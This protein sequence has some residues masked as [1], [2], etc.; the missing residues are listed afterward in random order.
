MKFLHPFLTVHNRSFRSNGV[1]K[2][3]DFLVIDRLHRTNANFSPL[4]LLIFKMKGSVL[5][6]PENG[7]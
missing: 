7:F 2:H 6:T 5:P 3:K 4:L 1:E